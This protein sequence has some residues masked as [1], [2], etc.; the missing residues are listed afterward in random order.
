MPT[1]LTPTNLELVRAALAYGIYAG[2]LAWRDPTDDTPLPPWP[3]LP[4]DQQAAWVAVVHAL[5][6]PVPPP[7]P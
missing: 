7:E 2:H 6:R 3:T 5:A 1:F 4:P